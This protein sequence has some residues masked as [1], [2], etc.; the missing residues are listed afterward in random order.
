MNPW[1]VNRG[2]LTRIATVSKYLTGADTSAVVRLRASSRR[3][4]RPRAGRVD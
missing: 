4:H 2:R 1:P 3:E